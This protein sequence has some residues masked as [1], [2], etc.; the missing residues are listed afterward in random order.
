MRSFVN[1]TL[2]SNAALMIRGR[3][4]GRLRSD[5]KDAGFNIGQGRIIA[6]ETGVRMESLQKFAD[7]FS[8]SVARVCI[9]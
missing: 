3:A 2:A 8:V 7:Y 9:L 1:A 4:I 5:M 6:G